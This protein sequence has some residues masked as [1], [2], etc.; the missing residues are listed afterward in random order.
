MALQLCEGQQNWLRVVIVVF[1][2]RHICHY[3]TSTFF[4][5]FDVF[6]QNPKSRDFT[7]FCRVLYVFLNYNVDSGSTV[8]K[9]R[10][11]RSRGKNI[12]ADNHWFNL[13]DSSCCLCSIY[14]CDRWGF[15]RVSKK[16]STC[17]NGGVYCLFYEW[18]TC[19]S[20]SCDVFLH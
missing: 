7:F 19:V 14:L 4:N 3:S 10:H 20:C 18:M 8:R 1:R 12:P 11:F 15:M 5:V 9:V 13:A 2:T 6:F 17:N 16:V